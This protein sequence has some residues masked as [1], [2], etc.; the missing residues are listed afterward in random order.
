M[1]GSGIDHHLV[2][3]PLRGVPLNLALVARLL[4]PRHPE[5]LVPLPVHLVLRHERVARR[6]GGDAIVLLPLDLALER[7][8]D[9]LD[10]GGGAAAREVALRAHL[11]PPPHGEDAVA[12]VG[13]ALGLGE[14]RRGLGLGG[15]TRP[16]EGAR[17]ELVAEVGVVLDVAHVVCGGGSHATHPPEL[18]TTNQVVGGARLL[19][20]RNSPFCL[21]LEFVCAGFCRRGGDLF[22]ANKG[23]ATYT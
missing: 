11:V 9:A 21:K 1:A 15:R 19:E 23:P 7:P 4:V 2:R 6:V 18:A 17:G 5:A 14:H 10:A 3:R 16:P 22:L 8:L 13:E 20:E 12:R